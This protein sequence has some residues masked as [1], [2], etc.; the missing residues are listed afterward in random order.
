MK[1]AELFAELGFKVDDHNLGGFIERL[2]QMD[3]TIIEAA[4]GLAGLLV[5]M[6]NI[7]EE[8][9]RTAVGIKTISIETGISAAAIQRWEQLAE[10][11]GASAGGVMAAIQAFQS[12]FIL[13]PDQLEKRLDKIHEQIKGLPPVIQKLELEA[14]GLSGAM[15]VL[16]SSDEDYYSRFRD[17]NHLTQQQINNLYDLNKAYK[18]LAQGITN[19]FNAF[20]GNNAQSL[21]AVVKD[22]SSILSDIK[23]LD[24]DAFHGVIEST[25][26][27]IHWLAILF[28]WLVKVNHEMR[29]LF[30]D[31]KWEK[32]GA[33][34]AGA[35]VGKDIG[36]SFFNST[37]LPKQLIE[38][39]ISLLPATVVNKSF[40]ASHNSTVIIN[41]IRDGSLAAGIAEAVGQE[42]AR[43]FKNAEYQSPQDKT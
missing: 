14:Y 8:A 35:G 37:N 21:T 26:N 40:Q 33:F 22:I 16:A 23:D 38:G 42:L 18:G 30:P 2:K 25:K 9:V 32:N 5:A 4:I 19:A 12:R 29:K 15:V 13:T 17:H 28:D 36:E 10:R 6:K 11:L 31:W 34:Q 43:I 7:T 1:V 39:P 24:S 27:L 41:G 20:V 3:L